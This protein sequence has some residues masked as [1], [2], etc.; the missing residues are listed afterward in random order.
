MTNP[1]PENWKKLWDKWNIRGVILFSLSLQTLLIL[2]AP[3]RKGT[4]NK[5]II[6]L[7]WSAYLLADW[8]ANFAV[9]L[10]SNSQGDHLRDHDHLRENSDLLA[11]WAPFLLLHLGGPD[12][13]TA[14]ALEDNELWLRHLL[15]LIFQAVAA[16]YVFLQSLP[17]NSLTIPT[18]LMFLAGIIKYLERT[19][20]LYLASLDRF[21][22]SML[23][24]PDPGP[25]YAKL[26]EEYASKREAKLPTQIIMIPEP[27][28]ES[29][30]TRSDVFKGKL[31]DLQ[32]VH[33]AYFYFNI[34]KGLLVDLI[35]SFRERN[36]S[37]DFFHSR[38]PEDAYRVIE[39]ELNFIYQVLYT[40]V[41]VVHSM[42]GY[43]FRF[44]AFG[45]IVSAFSYFHFH[46]KK[47]GFD[48]Y[49]VRITYV[50]FLGAV[51]LDTIALFMLIFSDRIF[52]ALKVKNNDSKR[53]CI[54]SLLSWFLILKR[55][56]WYECHTH[57]PVKIKHQLLATPLLVRRWSGYVSGHNLVRYCLKGRPT[58][59]HQVKG[60]FRLAIERII[61]FLHI[62]LFIQVIVGFIQTIDIAIERIIHVLCIDEVFHFLC[63]VMN[64]LIDCVGLTDFVDEIRYA[65]REPFTK[66]LWEFIFEELK[67]KSQFADDPEAAKR[68]S[69]AK[70]DWVLQDYGSKTDLSKLMS[71]VSDVTYDESLLLWHIATELLYHCD[72]D[73]I[74]EKYDNDREF[75]KVLSDYMLYLLVMQPTMM[76]A[77]AGIGKIRFRDTCA[78]A[79]R[80]FTRK[81]LKANEEK[82][83]CKHIMSV[84]TDVKPVAMKGDR[85]KSLLFDASM[86]AKELQRLEEDKWKLMSRIW[87]EML[88]FSA[89][90]CRARTHAQQVS[91]GGELITFVWLLMAHF[92][93]GEQFQINEGHARAKL[94]VGVATLSIFG[95]DK[96]CEVVRKIGGDDPD[97]QWQ[98]GKLLLEPLEDWKITTT[99]IVCIAYSCYEITQDQRWGS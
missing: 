62:N 11:F 22:D 76:S 94:M 55:P 46:V 33:Y 84:N 15:G 60:C 44:I 43:V 32:V 21:R 80:F 85:S 40:K 48:K 93:L 67:R 52:A 30:P 1:I 73:K 38:T 65:S 64:K 17:N 78:E 35:F 7:I 50:L 56:W 75:S 86:L 97:H 29:N 4:A 3:L 18:G 69:S 77:V 81:K 82:K 98:G 79:E 96:V 95:F 39:V 5:L 68:I 72:D 99:S 63:C 6:L 19:R 13:I 9:G 71:Y 14:F 88:S 26:M 24:Q 57:Q 92:G 25:N 70:G 10:I 51:G 34:F 31:N 53:S 8:A 90:H 83:A 41:E 74:D 66:E 27:D 16:V 54:T 61:C 2:M 28:K 91:K 45:S 12:T 23:K 89:S 87:V 36:E 49:D 20:A 58:S 47:T 37:R 42:A 59:V